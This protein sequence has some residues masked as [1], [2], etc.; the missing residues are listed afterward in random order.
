MSDSSG[1]I[2]SFISTTLLHSAKIPY[3][4]LG[5]C[6]SASETLLRC[7]TV[8]TLGM[9]LVGLQHDWARWALWTLELFIVNHF[10]TRCFGTL[11]GSRHTHFIYCSTISRLDVGRERTYDRCIYIIYI[12]KPIFFSPNYP[13]NCLWPDP[14]R[15]NT[16]NPATN[17]TI[18][19]PPFPIPSHPNPS[20]DNNQS[21][22]PLKPNHTSP[23]LTTLQPP[24]PT[25]NSNP[26]T[27]H[28]PNHTTH[29]NPKQPSYPPSIHL[30]RVQY[31]AEPIT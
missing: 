19:T 21:H 25:S 4:R 27:T 28:P 26:T 6:L 8:T 24:P 23:H 2:L 9:T 16:Q 10:G 13:P 12:L 7:I 17:G 15:Y 5:G 29:P 31:D 22:I 20:I 18:P 1:R 11:E 30:A 14:V 3:F